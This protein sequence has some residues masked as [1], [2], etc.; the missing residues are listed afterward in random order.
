MNPAALQSPEIERP[1]VTEPTQPMVVSR[2]VWTITL[3]SQVPE[4]ALHE[5]KVL[6]CFKEGLAGVVI[7]DFRVPS[8]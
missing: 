3:S 1:T 2:S 4:P 8:V 7:D 5:M 6:E